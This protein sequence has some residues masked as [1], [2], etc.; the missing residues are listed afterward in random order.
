MSDGVLSPLR[1][2]QMDER[3]MVRFCGLCGERDDSPFLTRW[4]EYPEPD[5]TMREYGH[6]WN[7]PVEM[8]ERE[9]DS[10]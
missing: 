5:G 10:S 1:S 2:C 8:R 9:K 3:L 6:A 4:C 7:P